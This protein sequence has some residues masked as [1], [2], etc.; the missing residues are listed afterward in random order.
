MLNCLRSRFKLTRYFSRSAWSRLANGS[1]TR[2]TEASRVM[3]RWTYP[4]LVERSVLRSSHVTGTLLVPFSSFVRAPRGA[5][6]FIP[7]HTSGSPDARRGPVKI[8]R[9][10]NVNSY[11]GISRPHLDR[12][13]RGGSMVCAG[14]D[15]LLF[16]ESVVIDR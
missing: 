13:E 2:K 3:Q 4:D 5:R 10:A 6:S 12:P 15:R 8:G 7:A 9:R 1:S 16:V 14:I 11:C